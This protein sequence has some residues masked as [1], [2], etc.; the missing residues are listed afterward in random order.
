MSKTLPTPPGWGQPQPATPPKK[1]RG[2]KIAGIG[3]GIPFGLFMLLAIIG[4]IVGPQKTAQTAHTADRPAVATTARPASPTP[5][6]TPTP[7]PTPSPTP[8]PAPTPAPSTPAPPS[9]PPAA[10]EP[11]PTQPPAKPTPA[12]VPTPA[13]THAPTPAPVPTTA[14]PPAPT[15]SAPAPEP[16]PVATQAPPPP[17]P[18][19]PGTTGVIMS[20]SGNYYR[21]GEFCPTADLGKSTVDSHGT[22]ITCIQ[23][24]GGHHWHY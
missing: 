14:P 13:P 23:E 15:P 12:P 16:A 18:V 19:G 6:P 8:P 24:S 4:A 21:A 9:T 5:T 11:A 1:R 22:S 7:S 3:C 17:S 10:P 2:L 20:P